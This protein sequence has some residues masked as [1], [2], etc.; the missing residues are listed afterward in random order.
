MVVL[1][2]VGCAA[3]QQ[4]ANF[5]ESVDTHKTESQEVV[6][7]NHFE[8]IT[9]VYCLVHEPWTTVTRFRMEPTLEALGHA[10]TIVRARVVG[11]IRL[12]TRQTLG[13][14][15]ISS[16]EIIEV[17]SGDHMVGDIIEIVEFASV[18]DGHLS[19]DGCRTPSIPQ[20]EYIFFIHATPRELISSD[21]VFE[22]FGGELGRFPVLGSSVIDQDL[23]AVF[24]LTS[25]YAD[26]EAYANLWEEVMNE[27]VWQTSAT[28]H[29]RK[30]HS[31]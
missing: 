29:L 2:L 8:G 30:R 5:E 22:L 20:Q 24:G 31:G 14:I 6:P 25:C 12:V 3:Q 28:A 1:L 17:F 9:S 18:V 16:L 27:Y 11:D 7:P 26:L 23:R 4:Y 19:T 15:T 13:P 21:A 10:P